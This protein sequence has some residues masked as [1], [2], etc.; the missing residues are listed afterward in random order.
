MK[1]P[2]R[3][4]IIGDMTTPRE[5]FVF[6][7]NTQGRHGQGA[8]LHAIKHH[9]AVYGYERG[10]IGNSYAIVT[11]NIS[12]VGPAVTLREIEIDVGFFINFAHR[13]RHLTFNVTKIG[14]G[15]AGFKEEEIKP[16]FKRVPP[17]V[18]LP[19]DWR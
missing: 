9:G 5:I 6:G 1:Q 12:G 3:P 19:E 10:V 7:S 11:K 18:N 16:F 14:C 2:Y 8:A 13:H 15:L 4:I 17:N